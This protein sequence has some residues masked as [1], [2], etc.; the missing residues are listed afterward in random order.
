MP[1]EAEWTELRE[2]CTWTW[3]MQNGVA[4]LLVTAS[5]GN[6]IFLP[7][8]GNRYGTSLSNTGS[9]GCYG[10]SSLHTSASSIAWHMAFDSDNVGRG[11]SN[12]Y[13]GRSV[14]PV[15]AE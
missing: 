12:R 7:A 11:S 4:G 8:A 5:N 15:C 13:N 2:N 14:R 1:T 3:T 9:Y 10:S 6:G